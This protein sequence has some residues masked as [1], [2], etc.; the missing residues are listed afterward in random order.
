[1]N[2]Q[3]SSQYYVSMSLKFM[4]ADFTFYIVLSLLLLQLADII[5]DEIFGKCQ[6]K[7][8]TKIVY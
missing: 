6:V 7:M 1:M 8:S 5:I 4:I 3:I 2:I